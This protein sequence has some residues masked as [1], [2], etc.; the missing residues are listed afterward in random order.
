MTDRVGPEV[1]GRI[2]KAIRYRAHR[3]AADLGEQGQL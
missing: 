1:R 3:K 2:T